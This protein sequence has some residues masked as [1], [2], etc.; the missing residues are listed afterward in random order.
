MEDR[1]RKRKHGMKGVQAGRGYDTKNET[2]EAGKKGVSAFS[3]T[4]IDAKEG[5]KGP[6]RE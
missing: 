3:G 6:P 1:K 2:G 5:Q 4:E